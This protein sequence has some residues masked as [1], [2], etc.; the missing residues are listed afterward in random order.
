MAILAMALAPLAEAQAPIEPLEGSTVLKIEND[1]VRFDSGD[2]T[3]FWISGVGDWERSGVML[4]WKNTGIWLKSD[5][6]SVKV[7]VYIYAGECE[8]LT[9]ATADTSS[10]NFALVDSL[11][12]EEEGIQGRHVSEYMPPCT[13]FYLKFL[14]LTG[15]GTTTYFYECTAVRERY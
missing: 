6:D 2:S 13:Y 12:I 10:Y 11:D 14:G 5:G 1:I 15:N 4:A 9:S 3:Y 7:R 8:L